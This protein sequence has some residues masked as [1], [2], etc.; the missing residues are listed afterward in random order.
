[1]GFKSEEMEGERKG[2]FEEGA[3]RPIRLYGANDIE[4]SFILYQ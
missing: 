4:I 1:M 3:V 2:R